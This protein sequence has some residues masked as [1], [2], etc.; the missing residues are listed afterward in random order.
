MSFGSGSGLS[1]VSGMSGVRG[2]NSGQQATLGFALFVVAAVALV[3]F[4]FKKP[5]APEKAAPDPV[6]ARRQVVQ[7]IQDK[8]ATVKPIALEMTPQVTRDWINLDGVQDKQGIDNL[9]I[10]IVKTAYRK[11]LGDTAYVRYFG[12][13]GSK[14]TYASLTN[15]VGSDLMNA[16][17]AEVVQLNEQFRRELRRQGASRG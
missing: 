16:V 12:A 2:G 7:V 13:A 15:A 10:G 14:W 11:H 9:V 6:A 4:L 8:A 17:R 1:T 5:P 3:G